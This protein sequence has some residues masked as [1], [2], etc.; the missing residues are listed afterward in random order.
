MQHQI[1]VAVAVT[2][3]NVSGFVLDLSIVGGLDRKYKT[4][5]Q[6]IAIFGDVFLED[7]SERSPLQQILDLRL[8]SICHLLKQ[9]PF[10]VSSQY[11]SEV[12]AL[13]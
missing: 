9:S 10:F 13:I 5:W 12:D 4:A 1:L 6:D 11:F 2:S 3:D 7:N 8:L